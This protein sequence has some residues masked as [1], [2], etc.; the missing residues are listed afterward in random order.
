MSLKAAEKEAVDAARAVIDKESV[1]IR[2]RAY[3][4]VQRANS[5]YVL[6]TCSYLLGAKYT[7]IQTSAA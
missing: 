4:F 3:L 1:E 5:Y 7:D 2:A 6:G